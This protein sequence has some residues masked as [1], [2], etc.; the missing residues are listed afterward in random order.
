MARD[1]NKLTDFADFTRNK[2]Q[3]LHDL[4]SQAIN[5][6]DGDEYLVPQLTNKAVY[7]NAYYQAGQRQSVGDAAGAQAAWESAGLVPPPEG[8]NR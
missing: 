6:F 7:D 4:G 3:V 1:F 5:A 8:D 2:H